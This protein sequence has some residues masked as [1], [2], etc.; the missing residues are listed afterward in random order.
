MEEELSR[1]MLNGAGDVSPPI[2]AISGLRR[3]QR[4]RRRHHPRDLD[5]LDPDA[6]E[7]FCAI[8]WS[9]L[10]YARPSAR[11]KAATAAST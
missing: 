4:V 1:D 6:F 9:K 3:W 10:G 2:S 5:D 8:L 7:A 11:P